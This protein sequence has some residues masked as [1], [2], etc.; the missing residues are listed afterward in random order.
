M[1]HNRLKLVV[2]EHS[3]KAATDASTELF[4]ETAMPESC[5]GRLR[6]VPAAEC[7]LPD[8]AA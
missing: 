1:R 3:P 2:L 4:A 8:D 5:P 6:L 7:P